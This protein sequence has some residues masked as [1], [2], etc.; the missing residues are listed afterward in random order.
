L[1]AHGWAAEQFDDR[2]WKWTRDGLREKRPVDL[3]VDQFSVDVMRK[4]STATLALIDSMYCRVT[5]IADG[6][7]YALRGSPECLDGT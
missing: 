7:W 2:L 4:N 5:R 1:R 6:T 3:F